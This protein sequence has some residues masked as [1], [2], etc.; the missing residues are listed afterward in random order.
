MPQNG[1]RKRTHAKVDQNSISA[2][3]FDHEAKIAR[4]S[5]LDSFAI[6]IKQIQDSTATVQNNIYHLQVLSKIYSF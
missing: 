3:L 4:L 5:E 1:N 6:N 2:M